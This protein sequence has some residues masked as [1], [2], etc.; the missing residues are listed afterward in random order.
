MLH[1]DF[2]GPNGETI[3]IMIHQKGDTRAA[4]ASG[5]LSRDGSPVSCTFG[6][7]T[8]MNSEN[9]DKTLSHP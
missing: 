4:T 3:V 2:Q 1:L 6:A 5:T 8:L 9:G 7:G